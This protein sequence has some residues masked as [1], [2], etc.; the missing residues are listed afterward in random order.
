MTQ[1]IAHSLLSDMEQLRGC[2]V[3]EQFYTVR[4]IKSYLNAGLNIGTGN[5]IVECGPKAF[6]LDLYRHKPARQV[7]HL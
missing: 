6:C 2:V 1:C 7:S 5:E 4:T 3:V